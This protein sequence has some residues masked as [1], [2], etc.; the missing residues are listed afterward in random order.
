MFDIGVSWSVIEAED[1]EIDEDGDVL[2]ARFVNMRTQ[3]FHWPVNAEMLRES[4]VKAVRGFKIML[5]L[6]PNVD[7][8]PALWFEDN[9]EEG[10]EDYEPGGSEEDSGGEDDDS[11]TESSYGSEGSGEVG[12]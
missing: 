6:E 2:F 11:F 4:C 9:E 12:R 3:D 7:I 8:D 1:I 10:D 5:G